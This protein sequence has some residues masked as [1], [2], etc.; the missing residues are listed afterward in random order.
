MIQTG[1]PSNWPISTMPGRSVSRT[2]FDGSS[3]DGASRSGVRSVSC[4]LPTST[5]MSI[6]WAPELSIRSGGVPPLNLGCSSDWIFWVAWKLTLTLGYAALYWAL[7]SVAYFVPNP[8]SKMTTESGAVSLTPSGFFVVFLPALALSP[9][10]L[11]LLAQADKKLIVGTE[12]RPSAA[13][14]L[15]RSRRPTPS[16]LLCSA[17]VDPMLKSSPSPGL[18]R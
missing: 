5:P 13:D 4:F 9:E 12:I 17:E 8:P 18:R 3:M 7:A 15:I 10:P 16:V 1:A 11:S 6:C 14:R 2:F